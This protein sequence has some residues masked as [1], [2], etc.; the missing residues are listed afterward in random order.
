MAS[1]AVRSLALLVI[2]GLLIF[3]VLPAL[4]VAAA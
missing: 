4:L 1:A 2:A 3:I